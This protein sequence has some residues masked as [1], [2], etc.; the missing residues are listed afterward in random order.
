M[1]LHTGQ[2]PNSPRIFIFK[3]KDFIY[4]FILKVGVPGVD[5]Y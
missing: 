2:W 1:K 4:L 3:Y 5:S